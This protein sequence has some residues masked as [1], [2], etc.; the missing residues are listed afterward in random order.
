MKGANFSLFVGTEA[1]LGVGF[2]TCRTLQEWQKHENNKT[3]WF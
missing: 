1:D 3:F 2:G